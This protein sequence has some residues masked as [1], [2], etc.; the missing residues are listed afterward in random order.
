[1]TGLEIPDLAEPIAKG[2][3]VAV[4]V[5]VEQSSVDRRKAA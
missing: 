3:F 2:K 4:T 1:M 5:F